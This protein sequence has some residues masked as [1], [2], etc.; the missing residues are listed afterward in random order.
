MNS[1]F[2][3]AAA[4]LAMYAAPAFASTPS[5]DPFGAFSNDQTVQP[6]PGRNADSDADAY[7]APFGDHLQQNRQDDLR[8]MNSRD[9]GNLRPP[10]M[11][12]SGVPDP[13]I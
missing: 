5:A 2:L 6:A 13:R 11:D 8:P 12:A 9:R 3:V 7:T 4:V 10:R 1:K